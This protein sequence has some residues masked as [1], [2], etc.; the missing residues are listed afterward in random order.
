ML[1]FAGHHGSGKT[2]LAKLLCLHHN[3]S[4]FDLGPALRKV[5]QD[6][7]TALSFIEWI[8]EGEAVFGVNFTDDI[9]YSKLLT[10]ILA[11][12]IKDK[13][14]L[15]VL[16]S[17]S[18]PGLTYL[19]L[20][21]EAK[22]GEIERKIVYFV[23]SD[24]SMHKRWMKRENKI[25]S[26]KSFKELMKKDSNMGLCQISESAHILF[27]NSGNL[28]DQSLVEKSKVFGII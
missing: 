28:D 7:D 14:K 25:I 22:F 17:R 23:C 2:H 19:H 20:S 21:L 10:F 24:E 11:N 26:L 5:H 3:F 12:R 27:E 8:Q 16:G 18:F 13:N 9:L 1:Y 6:A 4:C 15:I